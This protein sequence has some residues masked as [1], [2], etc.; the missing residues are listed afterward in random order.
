MCIIKSGD[1]TSKKV[2]SSSVTKSPRCAPVEG[3]HFF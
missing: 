3:S 1:G 2:E